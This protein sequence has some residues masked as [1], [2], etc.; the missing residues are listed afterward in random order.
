MLCE[1]SVILKQYIKLNSV[2]LVWEQTIPTERPPPVGEVVPTFADRGVSRGQRNKSPRPLKQ[3]IPKK[4]ISFGIK[5][6]SSVIVRVIG[7]CMILFVEAL[8]LGGR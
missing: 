6:T 4:Y 8:A 5:F 1:G 2:A 7:L 3:Y